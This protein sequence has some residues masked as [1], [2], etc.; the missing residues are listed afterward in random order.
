[1]SKY[2]KLTQVEHVLLRP[3]TYV[4]SVEPVEASMWLVSPAGGFERRTVVYRQAL[5]KLFDEILVNALDNKARD[6]NGGPSMTVLKV[7]VC[8]A[9]GAISVYND[10]AS[11]PVEPHPTEGCLVPELVFGCLLTG[12]NFDDTE[13]RATGGRNGYGAKLTSIFS[14]RFEVELCDGAKKYRQTWTRN[15]TTTGKPKVTTCRGKG[16][17]TKVTFV[18]DYPRFGLESVD[19][20]TAAIIEKRTHDAAAVLGAGVRVSFNGRRIAIKS[21]EHFARAHLAGAKIAYESVDGP[22]GDARWDVGVALAPDCD[23][24]QVSFVNGVATL[25]GGAH[26]NAVTDKV[27][28]AVVSAAAA[29]KGV[30]AVR[31]AAVKGC[32]FVFV[33]CRI[34]NPA[35]ASQTKD[36]LTSRVV[37]PVSETFLKKAVALVLDAVVAQATARASLTAEKSL[38]RTD[39]SKTARVTGIAKLTDAGWAGTAR[40]GRCTL[41]LTEGDSAKSL[42]VAGLS[43]IG[44]DSY[45]VFPLRGKLLNCLDAAPA[46]IAA[47]A[48]ITALKK[49]LGL[50]TGKRYEDAASLRYG[51]VMLM[52]DAD[53]DGSHITGLVLNFFNA[54]FPGLLRVPGFFK[55]FITPVVRATRGG[56]NPE[57]LSF[58]SVP[59]FEAWRLRLGDTGKWTAGKWT[60]GKWTVK[61]YKGL[62][63]S[64]SEEAKEY[65]SDLGRHVKTYVWT[66]LCPDALDKAF[67]KARAADRR[68]WIAGYAGEGLDPAATE[69]P[70]VDFVDRELVL[71]SRA[72]LERWVPLQ[73]KLRGS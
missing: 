40:S 7:D 11:V 65:F 24:A 9:T 36:V 71:F 49:I 41:I 59:D 10:G 21:F 32:L 18:P 3:D 19:D 15:M 42:A 69:V 67:N 72:D 54:C 58:Y 68:A 23:Q 63:T 48:E 46:A 20:D 70:V 55:G 66:D 13:T 14:E 2:V 57:K 12:S 62:G 60:A 27:S 29:K 28:K 25:G 31:P 17:Y 56:P 8:R 37:A 50:Q 26:V 34:P 22:G 4:G 45:G 64:T 1:M 43:V 39:G 33:N 16:S 44:R 6:A 52:T 51:H 53:V 30:G 38:K 61:Y 5:V 35:F 47:N 73:R